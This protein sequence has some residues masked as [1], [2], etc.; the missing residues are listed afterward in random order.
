VP[1]Y[2]GSSATF[3]LGKIGGLQGRCLQ[4]GD[5]LPLQPLDITANI[6]FALPALSS[7]MIPAYSNQYDVQ[8]LVGP[9]A[10][11]DFIT[12]KGLAEFLKTVWCVD[13]H[14]SRLGVRLVPKTNDFKWRWSRKDGGMGGLH[15]SNVIDYPY[16]IGG[17]NISG[18]HPIIITKDGPSLGGFVCIVTIIQAEMWKTGQMRPGDR[19][20][21]T[22]VTKEV[23]IKAEQQ[24][25]E[26]L[27]KLKPVPVFLSADPL[28]LTT[29]STQKTDPTLL[30]PILKVVS[31]S[32]LPTMAFRQSGEHGLLIEYEQSLDLLLRVRIHLLMEQI[33]KDSLLKECELS[34]GVSSLLLNVHP[35]SL[36]MESVIERCCQLE[37]S[38]CDLDKQTIPSRVLT[39]PIAFES[40]ATKQAIK[41]YQSSIK[42][43]APYLPS[44]INFIRRINGLSSVE[45]VKDKILNTRFMVLG[46]GDV[47]NGSPCAIPLDPRKQLVTSKYSPARTFTP[48]GVVGLGG[49]FLCIYG[50][51]S[52][53][54]YQLVGQTLPVWNNNA[55]TPCLFRWFDQ[56]QFVEV[57]EAALQHYRAQAKEGTYQYSIEETVFLPKDYVTFLASVRTETKEWEI[58]RSYAFEAERLCWYK[59][60]ADKGASFIRSRL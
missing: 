48:E 52:P 55:I 16:N 23:A 11:P 53:G 2:L 41:R 17:I 44:N 50:T 40:Q 60:E 18:E 57:T 10:A 39:I 34:P 35:T 5:K 36:L 59:Q 45:E 12:D 33:S 15:P 8:V 19:I 42:S 6:S 29:I 14:S 31:R 38:L 30:N 28:S 13:I 21:F 25:R 56:I 47:Y 46:L 32:T 9:Y 20:T 27:D 49:A 1:R 51:D 3:P 37:Q 24:Q 7:P 4:H 54:G 43:E 26:M 58:K 22:P